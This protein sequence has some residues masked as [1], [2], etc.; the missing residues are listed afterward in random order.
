MKIGAIAVLRIASPECVAVSPTLTG[1]VILHGTKN[2]IVNILGFFE[3][4]S[5]A[6]GLLRGELRWDSRHRHQPVRLQKSRE[7]ELG[8]DCRGRAGDW[9]SI[10]QYH[11]FFPHDVVL[12]REL[13]LSLLCFRSLGIQDLISIS[14]LTNL[15]EP[16]VA[17][18]G[19]NRH[20]LEGVGMGQRSPDPQALARLDTLDRE[21][22]VETEVALLLN[23]LNW[24]RLGNSQQRR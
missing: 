14:R 22:V 7:V 8:H 15:F 21:C 19:S 4:R 2:V 6:L 16:Q 1:L 20:I 17:A 3:L 10:R 12:N 5:R 23:R 18:F 13:V 9:F 24:S 11:M